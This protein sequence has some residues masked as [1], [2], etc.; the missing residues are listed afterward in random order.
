M[1]VERRESYRVAWR[2]LDI[3]DCRA[4]LGS[5]MRLRATLLLW[6]NWCA[7]SDCEPD[8][9]ENSP[10]TL[11]S[12]ATELMMGAACLHH[13]LSAEHSL[14]NPNALLGR[15]LQHPDM[16]AKGLKCFPTTWHIMRVAGFA[17]QG[18]PVVKIGDDNAELEGFRGAGFFPEGLTPDQRLLAILATLLNTSIETGEARFEGVGWSKYFQVFDIPGV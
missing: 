4:D 15:M 5:E 9:L 2:V 11:A 16:P 14:R 7:L 6:E 3:F 8:P 17:M 12:A 13:I 1:T 18:A 10:D